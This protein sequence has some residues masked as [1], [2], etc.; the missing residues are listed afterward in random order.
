MRD[1]GWHNSRADS[2]LAKQAELKDRLSRN[3]RKGAEKK[4]SSHGP[5]NGP[6]NGPAT[7]PANGEANGPAYGPR[8]ANPQPQPQP[9]KERNTHSIAP[10]A[11][12]GCERL[13][14][15]WNSNRGNLPEVLKLTLNRQKKLIAR[16]S[17]DGQFQSKLEAATKKAAATPFCNGTGAGGWMVTFDWL[18]ENNTNYVKVLEGNYDNRNGNGSHGATRKPNGAIGAPADKYAGCKPDVV[19]TN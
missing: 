18:I 2:E 10:S 13:V 19:S 14:A 6:A 11:P 12:G 17:Q 1:D 3:G 4:W 15:T 16:V 7:S 5:A 8:M 9:Q